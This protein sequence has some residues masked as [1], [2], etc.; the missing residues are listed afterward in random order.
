MLPQEIIFPLRPEQIKSGDPAE[1]E[2]Y[3]RDLIYDLTEMY[4]NIAQNVN[5]SL[6]QWTPSVSGF[7]VPGTGTYSFQTGWYL[8]Q[9]ILVDVWYDVEW[10]A[11]TGNGAIIMNMPFKA[12]N[13]ENSPWVG[14]NFSN[15]N[16]TAGYTN[17]V[18]AVKSNT[19]DGVLLQN[20]S[21]VSV[22][23]LNLPGSG[24]LFGHVRYVGKEFE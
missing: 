23:N 15:M 1:L 22:A 17:L 2:L 24:R 12:A 11:H 19:F 18:M 21:G 5:G 14:A 10:S 13:T 4:N 7:I 6:K 3:L 20:G 8:R 16:L 9:G